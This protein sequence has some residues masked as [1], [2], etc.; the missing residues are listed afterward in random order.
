MLKMLDKLSLSGSLQIAALLVI[1]SVL[2]LVLEQMGYGT[3]S[4]EYI[5]FATG[6]VGYV[7]GTRARGET[8]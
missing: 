5:A 4:R 7:L 6:T 1:T 8:P 3:A 2:M